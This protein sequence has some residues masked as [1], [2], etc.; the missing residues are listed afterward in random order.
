MSI[1][2]SK[3]F[4]QA[5]F[6]LIIDDKRDTLGVARQFIAFLD[7]NKLFHMAP[8]VVRHLERLA[9][10]YKE[11]NTL[12]IRVAH[13][14][15]ANSTEAIRSRMNVPRGADTLV[16]EDRDVL[17]GFVA[18]YGEMLYDASLRNQLATLKQRLLS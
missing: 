7:T 11:E 17:G 9:E 2:R 13:P 16:E 5:L 15:G 3:L 8:A 1:L 18:T 10:E 4:A 14:I 6:S 12:T